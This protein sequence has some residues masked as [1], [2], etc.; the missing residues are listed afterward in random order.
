MRKDGAA[1]WECL[2]KS[3]TTKSALSTSGRVADA[4][5]ARINENSTAH[6]KLPM[7]Y[8]SVPGT[9]R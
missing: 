8:A 7:R 6:F 9:W 1:T 4:K 2:P 3:R 5:V